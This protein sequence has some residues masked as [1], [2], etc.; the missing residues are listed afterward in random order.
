MRSLEGCSYLQCLVKS[1]LKY[2]FESMSP[3]VM[4]SSGWVTKHPV[5]STFLWLFG[6]DKEESTR[7]SM[8]EENTDDL[9]WHDSKGEALE[10]IFGPQHSLHS[11]FRRGD[12]GL[13]VHAMDEDA[14]N[15]YASAQGQDCGS[16]EGM[17]QE[18]GGESPNWGFYVSITPNG[19]IYPSGKGNMR[20]PSPEQKFFKK[21]IENPASERSA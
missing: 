17:T 12:E 10:T 19:E 6:E 2:I 14:E 3:E 18:N 5:I 20:S 8:D 15:S 21:S 1:T 7:E 11:R 4:S 9:V 16:E 13:G